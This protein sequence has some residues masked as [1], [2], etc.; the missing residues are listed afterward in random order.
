[1]LPPNIKMY[2]V[3]VGKIRPIFWLLSIT[4]LFL[5]CGKDKKVADEIA[6]IPLDLQISRFDR[7]FDEVKATDI[8]QLKKRYP[9]LF[10]TQYPDSVWEAKLRDTLQ[11]EIRKEVHREFPDLDVQK[12]ALELL[13]KHIHHYFPNYPAP[14]VITV[15]NEVDY[16]NRIILADSILFV[17]LDNYLGAD[18]KFYRGF[19]NY[20]SFGLDKE[21]MVSDVA[22]AFAKRAIPRREGR[23]FVARMIAHGKEL[24]LKDRLMPF[25][26]DA[27][28]IGY[29]KEDL[30]WARASEEPIWRNF[31]ENELLYSTDSKLAPR[32]LDP[33]PFSKFGLDLDNE[34]PGRIGRYMGWQIVRAFME[35]NDL[36]LEQM[37]RLPGEE[38]F[39]KSN[40]KP[41][42]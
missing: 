13:F 12:Q 22:A 41:K 5:G 37:L 39:V 19:P 6:K 25:A 24:Y 34:S 2:M 7:E 3:F 33:A 10:P 14:W 32:F 15:T 35:K 9:F 21:F 8:P 26:T 31:I 36:S 20:V 29:S 27:Q 40:Y 1:M 28:K 30:E 18:H 4:F 17:G 23:S 42:K 38:I 16:Q 11:I